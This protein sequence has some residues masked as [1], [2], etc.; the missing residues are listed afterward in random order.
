MRAIDLEDLFW[1]EL[2]HF[3]IRASLQTARS[4]QIAPDRGYGVDERGHHREY[5]IAPPQQGFHVSHIYVRVHGA[6]LRETEVGEHPVSDFISKPEDSVKLAALYQR[7]QEHDKPDADNSTLP[8][9]VCEEIPGDSDAQCDVA[10]PKSPPVDAD[11]ADYLAGLFQPRDMH[12][13]R[14]FGQRTVSPVPNLVVVLARFAR[15]FPVLPEE[16][17]YLVTNALWIDGLKL[18]RHWIPLTGVGG[19]IGIRERHRLQRI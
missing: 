16:I 5:R 19:D 4:L 11:M 9:R 18:K 1:C 8:L 2:S 17:D 12:Q 15:P 7:P 3:Q 6:K 13:C 10:E 14:A